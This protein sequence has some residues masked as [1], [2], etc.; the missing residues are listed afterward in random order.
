MIL[1]SR[2]YFQHK[3]GI[4]KKQNQSTAYKIQLYNNN[5]VDDV[6]KKYNTGEVNVKTPESVL[7]AGLSILNKPEIYKHYNHIIN[8]KYTSNDNLDKLLIKNK[9]N[10][11]L[12][13]VV[14]AEVERISKNLEYVEQV[15]RQYEIPQKKYEE[16][17]AKQKNR[18]IANR[19]QILKEVAI[20]ANDLRVSEGL[21]INNN[22]FSYRN[23][24]STAENLLRQSQMTSKHEEINSIND[25]YVNQGKNPVYNGKEWIWTG[26]GKTTRH[27]SNHLQ[28]RHLNE[29]FVIVN[30]TT[31]EIDE[32]MFPCDPE[33]GFSNAWICYCELEYLTNYF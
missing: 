23:L 13:R 9:A 20:Q 12:D 4:N 5:L 29:P 15:M 32:L 25:N 22:V 11:E 14:S 2:E 18:S 27:A 6:V 16:F 33:G 7:Y 19:Q 30:D 17:K 10:R 21:N 8:S 24:E 28:R 1:K 3:A 26:I 31:L